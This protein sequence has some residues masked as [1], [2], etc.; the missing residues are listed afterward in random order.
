M[1]K[2][3]NREMRIIRTFKAPIDLIWEVWTTPEHI[4]NWWGT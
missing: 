3:E 2:T 4:V 1:E